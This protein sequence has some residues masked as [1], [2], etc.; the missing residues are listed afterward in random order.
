[1]TA[2]RQLAGEWL[3]QLDSGADWMNELTAKTISDGA[4]GQGLNVLILGALTQPPSINGLAQAAD[5][6][7]CSVRLE[8]AV[9]D[10]GARPDPERLKRADAVLSTAALGENADRAALYGLRAL[11]AWLNGDSTRA[12]GY[13]RDSANITAPDASHL[14]AALVAFAVGHGLTPAWNREVRHA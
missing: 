10:R 7:E 1:M 9:T 14:S 13:A 12:K 8:A 3:T 2:S 11:F 4:A 6:G 5:Q